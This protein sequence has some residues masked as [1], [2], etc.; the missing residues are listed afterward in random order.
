[1]EN[2][3]QQ[4][5]MRYKGDNATDIL[6]SFWNTAMVVL[7]CCGVQGPQDFGP[8]SLFSEQFP[9]QAV[10]VAC[11]RKHGLNANAVTSQH[12]QCIHGLVDL[13]NRQ[14]CFHQLVHT[15]HP[16]ILIVGGVFIGLLVLQLLAM[17]LTISLF[18]MIV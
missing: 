5:H 14:G 8:G 7:D 17:S 10:P 15:M 1:M 9:G 6:S 13:V 12:Q 2:A 16:Y 3:A 4:L 18:R 11:C